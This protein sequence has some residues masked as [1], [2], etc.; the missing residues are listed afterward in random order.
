V[1]PVEVIPYPILAKAKEFFD[2]GGVVVGYGFLPSKSA[3]LG[4]TAADIG[5]LRDAIWGDAKP[6]LDVCKKSAAG[7][8]SYLLPE[9]PT[10][11]HLQKVLAEDA[12]IHPT[13]EVIEG[14]TDHWLHVLHRVKAGCEL[15]FITNQNH[16]GDA[17]R[18]KFRLT[19]EGEPEC[20]D[21]MRNEITSVPYVRDGK[22]VEMTMTFEPSE[23]VLLVF[24]PKKRPLPVRLEPDAAK[25]ATSI[26]IVRDATP[27]VP[28]PKLDAGSDPAA[29]LEGCSWVWYSEGTPAANAPAGKCFFRKQITLPEGRSIKS[30]VF[31]ATADNSFILYVN[32]KDAGHGDDSAEGWRNPVQ[33]DVKAH[34]HGGANVLAVAATNGVGTGA[35]PAGLIGRLSLTFEEGRSLTVNVDASWRTSREAS[36]DWLAQSFNDATWKTAKE[37]ARFGDGPW[38]RLNSKITLSPVKADPFVGHCEIPAT[39]DLAKSHVYLEMDSLAPEEAARVTVNGHDVGGF[40]GRPLRLD[41]TAHLKNGSNTVKIEPFAPTAARLVFRNR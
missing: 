22:Q 32:G 4:K 24:Q 18:F 21:A 33:L 34:L 23:S 3:T 19:A 29:G 41:V 36:G 2:R 9:K 13:L 8:R 31:N 39:A 35:N 27:P 40:I 28:E 38:G 25:P 11:E 20:W 14:K 37:I 6:G 26:A 7:G 17:R 10:P 12:G 30:A 15:F 1:P 5:G 16:L